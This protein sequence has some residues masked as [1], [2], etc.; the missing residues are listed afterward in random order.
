MHEYV[1]RPEMDCEQLQLYPKHLDCDDISVVKGLGLM[2]LP[3][4]KSL[5]ETEGQQGN[6]PS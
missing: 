1:L 6:V 2:P 3:H 5:R 4:H